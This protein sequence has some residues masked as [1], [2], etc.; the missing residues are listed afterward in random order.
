MLK[1]PFDN[2]GFSSY[3]KYKFNCA[4]TS[5][6]VGAVINGNNNNGVVIGSVDHD[7]WKSA[8][9][10]DAAKK[11]RLIKVMCIFRCFGCTVIF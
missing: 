9:H 1:V 2:D 7:H 6:E 5:Y 10:M 4:T 8:V 3:T 11:Q